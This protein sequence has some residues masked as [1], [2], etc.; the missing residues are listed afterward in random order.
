MNFPYLNEYRQTCNRINEEFYKDDEDLKIRLRIKFKWT[1]KNKVTK[2][3]LRGC[4]ALNNYKKCDKPAIKDKYGFDQEYDITSSVTRVTYL[5]N[6]KEWK[7]QDYDFYTEMFKK[8]Y[9][10]KA[11]S[12]EDRGALKSFT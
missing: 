5:L 7:D 10:N 2:I 6:K 3:K 11:C 12:P 9:P 1:K 4:C 8:M